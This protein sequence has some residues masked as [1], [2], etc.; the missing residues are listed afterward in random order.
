[1][2]ELEQNGGFTSPVQHHK[3]PA[4]SLE[5]MD[6]ANLPLV[7][8]CQKKNLSKDASKTP[9]NSFEQ[10]RRSSQPPYLNQQLF[11]ELSESEGFE[12]SKP[13]ALQHAM[14]LDELLETAGSKSLTL[15]LDPTKK[16][17]YSR[18]TI[19]ASL[20]MLNPSQQIPNNTGEQIPLPIST[21]YSILHG[22]G[23]CLALGMS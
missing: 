16:S 11:S 2:I 12:H 23:Y 18:V 8:P 17:K 10:T 21:C 20:D 9:V 14:S 7:A 19:T 22:C 13:V 1:M 6:I 5:Y 4:I 15:D 3:K